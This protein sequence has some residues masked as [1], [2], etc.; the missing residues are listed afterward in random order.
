M[1]KGFIGRNFAKIA[2]INAKY[3]QPRITMSRP[4]KWSLFLLRSYLLLLV[5]LLLY[6]FVTILVQ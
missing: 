6:K 2:E 5:G 1:L 3:A 4:V